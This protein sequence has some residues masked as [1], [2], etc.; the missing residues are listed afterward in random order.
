MANLRVPSPLV[1]GI[2]TLA[3]INDS[4]LKDLLTALE[5]APL[6]LDNQ[7]LVG[8][9]ASHAS[10]LDPTEVA[11]IV[12]DVVGLIRYRNDLGIPT[13]EFAEGISTSSDLDLDDE[14][15]SVLVERLRTFLSV[16]TLVLVEKALGVLGDNERD[17]AEARILTDARPIF[18]SETI[19]R[20]SAVVILHSLRIRYYQDGRLKDFYVALDTRD[21]S[22][23]KD[24]V[25]RAIT[26]QA[27]L[28]ASLSDT[29]IPYLDAE[30]ER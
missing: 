13:L 6:S 12:T 26:K 21:L 16:P 7:A 8:S 5:H 10:S 22:Q 14:Q 11:Q 30:A 25:E 3:T 9:V 15:R 1:R 23:L 2:R 18:A 27:A 29:G 17:F 19:D 20:P 28:V 4:A 24:V